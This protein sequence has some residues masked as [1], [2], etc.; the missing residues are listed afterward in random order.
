MT[1]PKWVVLH[2]VRSKNRWGPLVTSCDHNWLFRWATI[3]FVPYRSIR[4]ATIGFVPY[5]SMRWATISSPLTSSVPYRSIRATTGSSRI[6]ARLCSL[7]STP[8]TV[9]FR[10][11]ALREAVWKSPPTANWAHL[12][13][14]TRS[15]SSASSNHVCCN[16]DAAGVRQS[17]K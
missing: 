17:P 16:Y 7:F 14:M 3:G 10:T 6:A 15:T 4:W 9:L 11:P 1:R 13:A 8:A 5:R 2:I 12:T